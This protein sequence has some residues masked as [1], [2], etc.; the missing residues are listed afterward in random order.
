MTEPTPET[1]TELQLRA[2]QLAALAK[3]INTAYSLAK[4]ALS[5]RMNKRDTARPVL[6]GT[7]TVAATISYRAGAQSIRVTDPDKFQAW[8]D[9]TYP[10]EIE[11]IERV[12]PAFMSRFV[13]ANGV[14][15]GPSGEID[16]PGIEVTEPANPTISVSV[17]KAQPLV[18]AS[19][20]ALTVRE[21]I[22]GPG[23]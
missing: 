16:I 4:E 13:N 3:E 12:R 8:V 6:P 1:L 14:V 22:E 2:A 19:L 17:G 9:D 10:G 20:R 7:D 21:L 11:M 5:V 23:Q 15:V 18:L